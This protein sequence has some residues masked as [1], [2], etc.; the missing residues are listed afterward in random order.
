MK[1]QI[2]E[3]VNI[4]CTKAEHGQILDAMIASRYELVRSEPLLTAPNSFDMSSISMMF[5][6]LT[7]RIDGHDITA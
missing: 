4:E 7:L 6:R 3:T 2:L 5:T 1:T